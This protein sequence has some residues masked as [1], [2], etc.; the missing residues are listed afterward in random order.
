M[1]APRGILA[2]SAVLLVSRAAVAA[3]TVINFDNLAA[4]TTV[5]TQY[6]PQG[7]TFSNAYVAS[8]SGAHS[9]TRVLRSHNPT[10]E[11]DTGPLRIDF[12]SGQRYVK[13][14]AGAM[15]SGLSGTLKLFD[16]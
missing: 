15:S 10:G 8:D 2:A 6:G 3:P 5:T 12:S 4:G 9:G 16:A 11:F 1:K 7:V 13:F 14:Y